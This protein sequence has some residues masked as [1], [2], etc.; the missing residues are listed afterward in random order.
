MDAWS[1]TR[2][3]LYLTTNN[4][5]KTNIHAPGGDQKNDTSKRVQDFLTLDQSR[6]KPDITE[7]TKTAAFNTEIQKTEI[8]LI[9]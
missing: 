3:Y 1:E 9:V 8:C 4:T 7:I 2:T 6:R 5:N